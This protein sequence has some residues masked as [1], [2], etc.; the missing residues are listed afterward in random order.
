MK[1]LLSCVVLLFASGPAFGY[2]AV[3]GLIGRLLPA[4]QDQIVLED[5]LPPA[6][7]GRDAFIISTDARGR[8]VLG[9]SSPVAQASALGWYLRHTAG[10]EV[11]WEG[12]QLNL[13]EKLPPLAQPIQK[14]TPYRFRPYLNYCTL[15]YSA[16]FWNWQ[17]WEREIDVMA[18]NGINMPLSPIGL[19]GVWYN[20]LRQFAFTDA[21]AR[22]FL[23]GPAF[24]AWQWMT[25]IEDFAGPLPK[26][27]IE[28]HITLGQRIMKRQLDFGMTPIQQGF[29]GFVPLKMKEKFPQ[30]AI[31][32]QPPWCG[33]FKGSA[34]IDPLDPLF[35]KL[36]AAFYAEQKKLFGAHGYYGADPFHE[37]SPP[38][39]GD[40]YL[41]AVGK[42]IC[43]EALKADPD[44]T[45]CM[46]SWSLRTPIM[47]AIPKNHL[48]VLDIGGKWARSNAFDGYPFTIG[49]IHNFGGRTR[50]FG[51]L[52]GLARNSFLSAKTQN[53]NCIGMGLFPEAIQNNPVY[54]GMIFD[55]IWRDTPLDIA[56]WIPAYTARRYGTQDPAI[57]Q[58]WRLLLQSVYK[59]GT[60]RG[61]SLICASPALN[62]RQAD[63]NEGFRI[64]YNPLTLLSA[65]ETLLSA[66]PKIKNA[67]GYSFDLA[68]IGRQ[69]MADTL[70]ALHCTVAN[71]YLDQNLAAYRRAVE[72]FHA[73]ALDFD[74]LM[75]TQ[76]LFSFEK[77][78][79]DARAWGATPAEKDLYALNA[80]LQITQWGA[81]GNHRPRIC[82]YA[83]K[84]WSGL[85]RDYYIPRWA[86]FHNELEKN[87]IAGAPWP[88]E[89]KNKIKDWGRTAYRTTPFMNT[90]ADF[91]DP[92]IRSPHIYPPHH[93]GDTP[94]E[95]A[96]ILAKWGS[97]IKA[98]LATNPIDQ[99]RR[100]RQRIAARD[101]TADLGAP[102][103]TWSKKDCAL[104][105]KT[106]TVDITPAIIQNGQYEITFLYQNGGARLD[107]AEATLLQN[108]RE[109]SKDAHPGS[110]GDI[111]T[112]NT[113]LLSHTDPIIGATFTL[114]AKVKTHGSTS[115]NGKIW[116][117][118][119]K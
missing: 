8:L 45:L 26:N 116:V 4:Y 62:I 92:W 54:F 11:S 28:T 81:N 63:P 22:E 76:P 10:C 102:V 19:E 51:D 36:A 74:A 43:Q 7:G 88:D 71:A 53:P 84:E 66:S 78:V 46:Q 72:T 77:W 3:E 34:Q 97:H 33:A 52:A 118:L 96:R 57:D 5:N 64:D 30:A 25:N 113:Y 98:S 93:P 31:R 104:G 107:I 56:Q 100:I 58:A 115:S 14:T 80:A 95:A 18:L 108:G 119:R 70:L 47:R 9:G 60:G 85:I 6:P 2:P 106:W 73:F 101:T 79:Q 1:R 68:D 37:S 12:T 27:W 32:Q 82:E 17:R 105:W 48:L 42:I 16:P 69:V 67:P 117:R 94:A 87:L 65:W 110:T 41:T 112:A 75:K 44:A 90:L 40:A 15:S 99:I 21:E 35:P 83:W 24:F 86:I 23:V 55:L 39:A 89:D 38:Q 91:E 29:T 111:N 20:M 103:F 59:P 114:Q 109:I 49:T 50:L 61:S 13:P